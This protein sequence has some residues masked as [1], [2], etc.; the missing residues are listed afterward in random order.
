MLQKLSMHH[1]QKDIL[2]RLLMVETVRFKDLKPQGMESNIFMYHLKSLMKDS[3]VIKAENGYSLTSK[4]KHFV[5]RSQL[6][7]LKTWVQPKI[8]VI[9]ALRNINGEYAILERL[10][11]PFL[12]YKGF[13]SGKLHYGES[14]AEAAKR[15]MEEKTQIKDTGLLRIGTFIMRFKK[16]N[17]IV[18]H[19][20]GYVFSGKLKTNEP[21]K[22]SSKFFKCYWGDEGELYLDNRFGGHPELMK[23][24]KTSTHKQPFFI[25]K[26]FESSYQ[27]S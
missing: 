13:P 21:I 17:E 2:S 20:I 18:N 3:M 4:G 23:L 15:V 1:I 7:S 22:A 9:I 16:E 12:G 24:I 19:I 11:Q 14:L 6:E 10:H 8:I 27:D 26:E 25:E 5:D